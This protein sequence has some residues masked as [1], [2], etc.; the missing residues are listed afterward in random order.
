MAQVKLPWIQWWEGTGEKNNKH[1]KTRPRW[2]PVW[3]A[4]CFSNTNFIPTCGL[5]L[6]EKRADNGAH[7]S[8]RTTCMG[9]HKNVGRPHDDRALT[10]ILEN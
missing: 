5:L 1:A 8:Q 6:G 7:R 10:R 2:R 4:L 3:S 9:P